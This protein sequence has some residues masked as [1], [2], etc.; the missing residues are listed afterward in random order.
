LP[1]GHTVRLVELRVIP[2]RDEF[3]LMTGSFWID[4]ASDEVV[5]VV[6]RPA[7]PFDFERDVSA[8]DR[9]GGAGHIPGAAGRRRGSGRR[10]LRRHRAGAE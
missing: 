3:R 9:H 7:R 8:S 6:F 1:D 10:D 5:R 2:R 4:L